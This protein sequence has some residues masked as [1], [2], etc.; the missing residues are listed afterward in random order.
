MKDIS[1]K[2]SQVKECSILDLILAI[3]FLQT[4][5]LFGS[6]IDESWKILQRFFSNTMF[7]WISGFVYIYKVHVTRSFI[8]ITQ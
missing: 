3:L 6:Q 8:K 7:E 1:Q 2:A 5:K 4:I